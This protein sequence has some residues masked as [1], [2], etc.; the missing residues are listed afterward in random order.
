MAIFSRR[1]VRLYVLVICVWVI[2][3]SGVLHLVA[4]SVGR[5]ASGIMDAPLYVYPP[6]LAVLMQPLLLFSP[7]GAALVWFGVNSVLLVVGLGLLFKQSNIRYHRMRAALL[8]LPML[9]VPVV[10]NLYLGQL[11]ILMLVLIVLAYL[12]FVRKH[13]YICGALLALATWLKVWPIALIGYYYGWFSL[14]SESAKSK[15]LKLVI[16]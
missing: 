4:K 1:D 5:G 11:N 10:R 13:P 7:D 8:L 9:F 6:T 3:L 15:R 12:A 2:V 16:L 14:Y